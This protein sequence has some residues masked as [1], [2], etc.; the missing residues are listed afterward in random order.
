MA[1]PG[2]AALYN[3]FMTVKEA[4]H[5]L[6]DNLTDEE[7]AALLDYLNMRADPDALTEEE[8]SRVRQARAELERGDYV[9]IEELRKELQL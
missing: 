6:V 7:A 8:M 4:I 5:H 2:R 1:G 9:T 3:V